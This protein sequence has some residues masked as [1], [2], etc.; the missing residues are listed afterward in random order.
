MAGKYVQ[1]PL[2]YPFSGFSSARCRHQCQQVISRT[3]HPQLHIFNP[4]VQCCDGTGPGSEACEC[5]SNMHIG[6]A[7]AAMEPHE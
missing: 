3:G 1:F 5:S 7:S 4:I 2:P 6:G